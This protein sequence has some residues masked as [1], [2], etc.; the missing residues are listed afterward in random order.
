MDRDD[1]SDESHR[2][3][4]ETL[5]VK[6]TIVR[7]RQA[8]AIVAVVGT[9]LVF[10][11]RPMSQGRDLRRTILIDGHEAAAGEVIVKLRSGMASTSRLQLEQQIDAEASAPVGSG[12]RRMRSRSYDVPTLLAFLRTHPDVAYAEPNYILHA[13]ATPND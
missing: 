10:G 4:R 1:P 3:R 6:Q 5:G 12:M 8:L 2:G 13:T 9:A 11:S 7:A